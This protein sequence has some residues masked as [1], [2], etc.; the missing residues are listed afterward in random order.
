MIVWKNMIVPDIVDQNCYLKYHEGNKDNLQ[1]YNCS[2][3]KL[4]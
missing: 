1:I 3:I 2:K 4:H